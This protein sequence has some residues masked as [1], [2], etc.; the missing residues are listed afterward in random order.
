M[1]LGWLDSIHY[2]VDYGKLS[3]PASGGFPSSAGMYAGNVV[4]AI[5]GFYP[6]GTDNALSSDVTGL[7]SV[8]GWIYFDSLRNTWVIADPM[9]PTA[10]SAPEYPRVQRNSE[11]SLVIVKA[12][13]AGVFA[14]PWWSYSSLSVEVSLKDQNADVSMSPRSFDDGVT[15]TVPDTL[16]GLVPKAGQANAGKASGDCVVRR[17]EASG[18]SFTRIG[19]KPLVLDGD[20]FP[21]DVEYHDEDVSP[22]FAVGAA[23]A[24]G[25]DAIG[26]Y[27]AAEEYGVE[28]ASELADAAQAAVTEMGASVA[29]SSSE[30]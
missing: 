7:T 8:C 5:S 9:I 14:N 6:Q 27:E 24:E 30:E 20:L 21:L 16:K 4:Y 11:D 1:D 2:L 29:E 3:S 22:Y 18:F 17:G 10:V 25:L 28:G 19:A 26:N 13:G 12:S 23:T 15:V